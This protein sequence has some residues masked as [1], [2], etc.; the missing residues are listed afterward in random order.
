MIGKKIKR[1]KKK[2]IRPS[3]EICKTWKGKNVI[4]PI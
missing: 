4:L 1:K 2:I 3:I